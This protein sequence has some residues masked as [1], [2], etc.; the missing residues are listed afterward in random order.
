MNYYP[1]NSEDSFLSFRN[2]VILSIL[3]IIIYTL[4]LDLI[5]PDESLS[6]L[7]S[8]I[9]API[10]ELCVV[11]LLFYAA[12]LSR[13][14]GRRVQRAWIL[15][16][17]A[18]LSYFIGETMWGVLEIGLNQ[19]P[20]PS[21]A[22]IFY[23][24]FYFIF[25]LAIFYLPPERLKK[26]KEIKLIIDVAIVILTV[27]LIFW[28][29]LILPNINSANDLL[30]SIISVAY[31]IGDFILI[32]IL[33]RIL[34][35]ISFKKI[36]RGPFF[37]LELGILAQIISDT[38]YLYQS[39]QGTYISGGL[40][41]VG[42]IISFV[43]IGLAAILQIKSIRYGYHLFDKFE[44]L[45]EKLDLSTY[46]PFIMVIFTYALLIWANENLLI[47]NFIYVEIGVGM[48][49]FLILLRQ[50][51]TVKENKSLYLSAKEEIINRKIIE[52][53]LINSKKQFKNIFDNSPIGIFQSSP[54]GKFLLVNTAL[55][56]MLKYESP[57][58]LM[59]IVN[60][61]S[62]KDIYVDKEK[63]DQIIQKALQEP[64]WQFHEIEFY[65]KDGTVITIELS[66]RTVNEDEHG[67][68]KY[69]EGFIK[70]IT[71]RKMAEN[72]AKASLKEKELLL[73]EIHHRVKNNMQIIISMLALQKYY[74]EHDETINILIEIQ[75]RVKSMATIHEMLYQ[76]RDLTH[77]NFSDYISSLISDLIY[78]YTANSDIKLNIDLDE[79]YLNIETAIPCGL[80]INELVTNSIKHAFPDGAGEIDIELR[81]KEGELQLN[82]RDNGIGFPEE[83]DFKDVKSS[84]GLK[85][86]NLLMEQI[87]GSI[88]L[89]RSQGTEFII[90]FRELK[91]EKRF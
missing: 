59:N 13:V 37:L 50:Y 47:S 15:I 36:H 55:A 85:L 7:F 22:D 63:R 8:D 45:L 65:R 62:I 44:P 4:I 19:A 82:I 28:S 16:A 76:S 32:L 48:V 87:E 11:I 78:S 88:K 29:F 14:Q 41:D 24:L 2:I 61:T 74:V 86:V 70:D 30:V 90:K 31:V 71:E 60:K 80:I 10:I 72:D 53:N 33:I 39:I 38:I 69:L 77:I 6:I 25:A 46:L 20:F 56:D 17:L 58:D 79:A 1:G 5:K 81:D 51:L 67:T 18:G 54:E 40:L 27:S 52:K 83:T 34:V 9:S 89:D 68:I 42:W 57:E 64:D 23:L 73:K 35:F 66:F 84:L 43:L 75:N 21:A 26:N 12:R 3:F 49:I 91:Y